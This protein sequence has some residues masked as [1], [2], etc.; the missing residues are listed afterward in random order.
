MTNKQLAISDIAIHG[1][2]I[3]AFPAEMTDL[4]NAHTVKV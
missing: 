2:W 4:V 1:F 3:S